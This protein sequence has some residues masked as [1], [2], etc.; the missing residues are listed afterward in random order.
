MQQAQPNPQAAY[1][2]FVPPPMVQQPMYGIGTVATTQNPGAAPQP[3][4]SPLQIIFAIAS[5]AGGA[6][7]AYHGYKR[8]GSWGSAVGWSLGG[9]ILPVVV[10][11]VMLAQGFAKPKA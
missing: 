4:I 11:P 2:P 7:G 10:V 9:S 8:T 6:A 3:K 5:L 1:S